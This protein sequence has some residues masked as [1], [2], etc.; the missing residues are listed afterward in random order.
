MI[1]QG[2]DFPGVWVVPAASTP[3]SG[4]S[5]ART[6]TPA[7]VGQAPVSSHTP[8]RSCP[9]AYA[10]ARLWAGSPQP[11]C[12][13]LCSW[14]CHDSHS[15]GPGQQ[16]GPWHPSRARVQSPSVKGEMAAKGGLDW[17]R[18]GPTSG[19]W[20][21]VRSKSHPSGRCPHPGTGSPLFAGHVAFCR[22]PRGCRATLPSWGC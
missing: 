21:F 2:S 1:R 20:A 19:A 7:A 4:A 15:L 13:Q 8:V 12:P 11:A 3:P 17:M 22:L 16:L 10:R 18:P 14:P 6:R 5:S 9:S